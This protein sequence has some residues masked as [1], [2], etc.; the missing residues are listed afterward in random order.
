[1]NMA[2]CLLDLLS[3]ILPSFKGKAKS[4]PILK[5]SEQFEELACL[6]IF[7]NLSASCPILGILDIER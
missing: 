4:K 1:M 5:Y 2:E 7:P 3:N 6:G